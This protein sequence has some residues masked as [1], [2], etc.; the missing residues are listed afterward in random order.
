MNLRYTLLQYLPVLVV[1]ISCG[2]LKNI[3]LDPIEVSEVNEIQKQSE[4]SD[5]DLQYWHLL[6]IQQDSIP[7]MSVLRSFGEILGDKEGEKVIVAIIDSGVDIAHPC[8]SESVWINHD[9]IPNNHL[10]DDRNGYVDDVHGWN[11]L[12][13]AEKENLEVVRL[14]KTAE[15]DGDQYDEYKDYVDKNLAEIRP[16]SV[17]ISA[18]YQNAKK[19]DSIVQKVLGKVDYTVKDLDTIEM[20]ESNESSIQLLRYMDSSGFDLKD[21]EEY[22]DYL[23]SQLHYHY[24]IDFEGRSIVGDDPN[25]FN[26][27][28]YGDAR[29]AGPEFSDN[30]H[31]THVSGIVLFSCYGSIAKPNVEIMVLRAVPDGDEYDKDVALAIR[32]AVDNGADIINTSFG[33]S[34][35]PHPQWIY[36]ALKHAEEQDVLVVNAAGNDGTNINHDEKPNFI[37]DHIDGQEFVGNF[38]TV[39]ATSLNYNSNQLASFSNYGDSEVDLFAPG[40]EIYSTLPGNEKGFNSGTSMAAPNVTAVSA[41][42]RSYFPKLSASEIKHVLMKSGVPLFDPLTKPS[43]EDLVPSKE[44]AKSPKMINLYNALIYA[45]SL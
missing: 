13:N 32:Y 5:S 36:D 10:D 14:L 22:N 25:D 12:G 45:S 39:G 42:L 33:K 43:S 6:D 27:R 21:L 44:L 15:K 38:I 41:V 1:I 17:M 28:D 2:S 26:S 30:S 3:K 20:D 40:Q 31:G 23:H 34:F 37:R 19:A 9:E 7:G 11:F 24:N 16:Q 18:M 8:L 4:L 35:S 29:V